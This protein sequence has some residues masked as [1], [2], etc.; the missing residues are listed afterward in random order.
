MAPYLNAIPGATTARSYDSFAP[1][2]SV[3][4]FTTGSIVAAASWITVM[5][6][7]RVSVS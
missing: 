3:V 6:Y 1:F 4:V 5:P 2:S 7:R